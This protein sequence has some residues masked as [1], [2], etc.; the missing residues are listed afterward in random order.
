[1]EKYK[2]IY[3]NG[4]KGIEDAIE[5]YL[6]IF[7]KNRIELLLIDDL[8]EN[9]KNLN[10]IHK[11]EHDGI[12]LFTTGINGEKL[13]SVIDYFLK[14]NYAPERVM[15]FD[16]GTAELFAYIAREFKKNHGTKFYFPTDLD[17]EICWI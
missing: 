4:D 10:K 12:F 13:K 16:D 2:F 8:Y 14:I 3:L 17:E 7:G 11:I 6:R 5:P 9:P 15:F 1:M